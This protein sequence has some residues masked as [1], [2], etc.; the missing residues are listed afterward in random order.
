MQH[1]WRS[2]RQTSGLH[3]HLNAVNFKFILSI[4][5]FGK[6]IAVASEMTFTS[7]NDKDHVILSNESVSDNVQDMPDGELVLQIC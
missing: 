7:T 1:F 5:F 6:D 2:V 4:L 3:D